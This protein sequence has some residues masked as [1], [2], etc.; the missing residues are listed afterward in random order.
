MSRMTQPT[1]EQLQAKLSEARENARREL[2]S[3]I[4]QC[5]KEIRCLERYSDNRMLVATADL[6]YHFDEV[7]NKA[8][9]LE[10]AFNEL[11]EKVSA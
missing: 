9:E 1:L 7:E 5:C 6:K 4:E 2:E 11:D 3:L 8:Q 10:D